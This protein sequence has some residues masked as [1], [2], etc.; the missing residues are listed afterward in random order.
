MHF[1]MVFRNVEFAPRQGILRES[2]STSEANRQGDVRGEFLKICVCGGY[3]SGCRDR[4]R[5]VNCLFDVT[6]MFFVGKIFGGGFA[7]T[8]GVF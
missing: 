2:G 5:R 1:G 3:A 4:V 6:G 8:N 7:V